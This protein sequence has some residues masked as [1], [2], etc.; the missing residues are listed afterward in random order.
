M[1]LHTASVPCACLRPAPAG[2]IL[3]DADA[4]SFF[5][6]PTEFVR[7][8][9]A[10]PLRPFQVPPPAATLSSPRPL[11]ERIKSD[12]GHK[13]CGEPGARKAAHGLADAHGCRRP[14]Q[15]GRSDCRT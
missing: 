11:V 7:L 4:A 8:A 10:R 15:A 1:A 6:R 2:S 12:R 9:R 5:P 3:A 14:Q 13:A